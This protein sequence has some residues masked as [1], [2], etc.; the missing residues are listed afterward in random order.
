MFDGMVLGSEFFR[1]L[2]REDAALAAQVARRR[3]PRCGG[4][5]HRADYKRKPRGGVFAAAGEA[6]ARRYSLCCGQ[7]RRRKLPPSLRFLGRRVYLAVVVIVATAVLLLRA[8]TAAIETAVPT[9]TLKRWRGWWQG[10]FRQSSVFVML[11][12]RLLL[13]PSTDTLPLSML[14][15]VEGSEVERVAWLL[16]RLKP[17]TC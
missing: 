9:R 10:P 11:C 1:A 16:E 4:P 5:L 6:F 15:G 2:E 3:C 17:L 7:C 8:A 12:A 14:T 13:A